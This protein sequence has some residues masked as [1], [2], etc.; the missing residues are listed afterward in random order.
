MTKTLWIVQ[1]VAG[2]F[3]AHR[4]R[5]GGTLVL[6]A[7][8]VVAEPTLDALHARLPRGLS[9]DHRYERDGIVEA[10]AA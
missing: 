8:D 9:R 3:K 2:G 7:P 5:V 4:F 6:V 10:W 1:A